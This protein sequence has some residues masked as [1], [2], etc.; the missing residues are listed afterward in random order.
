MMLKSRYQAVFLGLTPYSLIHAI[1]LRQRNQ[2]V[3]VVDDGQLATDSPGLQRLTLLELMALKE[4]GDK[5]QIPSLQQLSNF[6]HTSTLR[7]HLPSSQWSSGAMVKDNLR[8]FVRKFSFLQTPLLLQT[9]ERPAQELEAELERAVYEFLRWFNSPLVRQRAVGPYIPHSVDWLGE[10]QRLVSLEQAKEYKGPE[11]SIF[12]QMLAAYAAC[13]DQVVKYELG[14]HESWAMGLHLLSPVWELDRRWF[15]RE[16]MRELHQIGGHTKKT[17]IHSWQIYKNRVE[18]AL[19]NS[20]EGVIS[21]D[22]LLLYGMPP[23]DGQLQ[24]QF[25]V[26]TFRGLEFTWRLT[27]TL[28]VG[29][30]T[31][32]ELTAFTSSDQM[33]TAIPLGFM[34]GR[35]EDT[36]MVA[37][38]AEAPGAKQEFS[39]QEAWDSLSSH[40]KRAAPFEPFTHTKPVSH[41]SWGYWVEDLGKKKTSKAPI[42]HHERRPVEIIDRVSREL[43]SGV[44]FWGPLRASRFGP[45]GFLADLRAD[46]S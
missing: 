25:N 35:G 5:Y 41:R 1:L 4:I 14:P 8:E 44:E 36:R 28:P 42:M 37:L 27:P 9:L 31:M 45:V 43:L 15:E 22:R 46:Q 3:L 34:E 26:R 33:G 19:L 29:E 11:L 13:T 20:Y 12:T 32:T 18:A 17:A 2:D 30:Q 39:M 10:F 23:L 24:C 16:L 6:L 38:I 7:V 40:L 21:H